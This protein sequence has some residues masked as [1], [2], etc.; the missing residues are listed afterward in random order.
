MNSHSSDTTT[1]EVTTGRKYTV[2]KKLTPRN[3]LLI[4]S[5][6]TRA[7]PDCTGTITTVK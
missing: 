2:R 5:A 3:F 7:R 6:I 1:M 4:S